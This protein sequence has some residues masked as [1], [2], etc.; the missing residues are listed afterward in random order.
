MRQTGGML[1]TNHVLSGALVGAAVRNPWVAFPL[2]V[3]SHLALDATPHWGSWDSDEHFLR[4]CVTDGLSGL[5]A[6]GVATALAEPA[7]RAAVLA[8]MVGAALPDLDKPSRLFFKRSPFPKRFDDFHGWIQDEAPH[9]FRSHELVGGAVFA[10]GFAAL[11]L[12]SGFA[13][14]RRG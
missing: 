4:I 14:R 3:V 8:G 5:A 1:V 11:T 7:D 9:R 13:R 6:M 10:A 2:G 12:W